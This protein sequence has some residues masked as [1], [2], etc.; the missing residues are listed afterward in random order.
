[1]SSPPVFQS[2]YMDTLVEGQNLSGG[3][4]LTTNDS[5]YSAKMEKGGLVLFLNSLGQQAPPYW[6]ISLWRE[7]SSLNLTLNEAIHSTPCNDPCDLPLIYLETDSRLRASN[8]ILSC[9]STKFLYC[10]EF[11]ESLSSNSLWSFLRLESD[12]RLHVYAVI[13]ASVTYVGQRATAQRA[14]ISTE[15]ALLPVEKKGVVG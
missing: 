11:E 7:S 2:A 8:V 12:G 6:I 5:A 9:S 4:Q 13:N 14:L 15:S 3:M 10:Y 1:M